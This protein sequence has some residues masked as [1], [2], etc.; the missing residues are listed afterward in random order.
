[1]FDSLN[2]K[3]YLSIGSS[4]NVCRE[5]KKA[6][7]EQYDDDGTGKRLYADGIRNAVGL[8]MHPVTNKLWANNNGSDWQGNEIPPEWINIIRD[9]GFYGH[10]FAYANQVW[11]NFNAH[12]NYQALLPITATD[13]AKVITMLEPAALIRA[14]SAPMAITFLN[15]SFPVAY[16]NGMITALR[17]SWNSPQSFRGYKVV[18]LDLT[19]ANDTSAN[20]VSDFI[21]GFL[22]DTVNRV[23]W[24]R[25][26]GLAVDRSGAIYL[27][28]DEA[29][30][31]ILK[32]Y[33]ESQ[34]GIDKR[35]DKGFNMYPN[36]AQDE[37]VIEYS[38][39]VPFVI[40][41]SIGQTLFSGDLMNAKNIV[42]VSSLETGIY[43]IRIGNY[44]EKFMKE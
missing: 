10:P 16:R 43:F 24:G 8:C 35:E 27:S 12:S 7:I 9:G 37:I 21:D 40:F 19:D 44:V 30:R 22:T 20:F 31:F 5:N 38:G 13:S 42:S 14:H 33:P 11:F 1:V 41:N 28:S 34:N 39:N 2:H 15:P 4:C 18:Y 32:I 36:P 23:Y 26:V 6:I 25:P 29:N 3:A 17:G